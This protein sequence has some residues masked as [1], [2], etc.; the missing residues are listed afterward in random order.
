MFA[1]KWLQ[2]FPERRR[3][4]LKVSDWRGAKG[5]KSDSSRQE[6]SKNSLVMKIGFDTAENEPRKFWITDFSADH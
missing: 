1:K 4:V 5:C 6:P 3:K 2:I